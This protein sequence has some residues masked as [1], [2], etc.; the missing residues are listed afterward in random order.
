MNDDEMREVVKECGLDW[1]RGYMPLFDSDPTN[2]YAV[3]I[4]AVVAAERERNQ[5]IALAWGNTHEPGETVNA[6]N[7]A[8]KI[9][10]GIAGPNG[11][12]QRETTA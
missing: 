6:R 5:Q 11:R 3:L 8:S 12:H 1:H 10:R 7:A 2:R 9:A 4:E